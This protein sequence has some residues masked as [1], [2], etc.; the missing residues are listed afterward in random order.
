MFSGVAVLFS[1]SWFLPWFPL[2]STVIC[3][4]N[5]ASLLKLLLIMVFIRAIESKQEQLLT[6]EL[7]LQDHHVHFSPFFLM[8]EAGQGKG[9][10]VMSIILLI[11]V[12]VR[13]GV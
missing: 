11:T 1:V 4:P 7:S 13:S 12:P 3:K 9:P 8:E 2:R 5:K 6:S 10:R